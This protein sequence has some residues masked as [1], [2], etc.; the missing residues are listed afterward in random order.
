MADPQPQAAA[1]ALRHKL[2]ELVASGNPS[3]RP[4]ID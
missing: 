3:D 4:L 2:V 1:C